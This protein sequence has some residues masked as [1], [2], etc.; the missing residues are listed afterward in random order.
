MQVI[1]KWIETCSSF[2]HKTSKYDVSYWRVPWRKPRGVRKWRV[3]GRCCFAEGRLP[4]KASLWEGDFSMETWKPS[5]CL[6]GWDVLAEALWG[7][8]GPD[9]ATGAWRAVGEGSRGRSLPGLGGAIAGD[10]LWRRGKYL[11]GE[12]KTWRSRQVE[13]GGGSLSMVNKKKQ[14]PSSLVCPCPLLTAAWGACTPLLMN[15]TSL[16]MPVLSS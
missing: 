11:R 15:L 12:I 4:A 9:R 2:N 16:H 5:R 14:L 13:A 10:E 1:N 8:W 7:E 6:S 3:L